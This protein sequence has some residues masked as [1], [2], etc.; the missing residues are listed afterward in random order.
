MAY[1]VLKVLQATIAMKLEH[2][3]TIANIGQLKPSLISTDNLD[4]ETRPKYV[5][6]IAKQAL[7]SQRATQFRQPVEQSQQF[8]R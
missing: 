3:A 6:A 5:N 8:R 2:L 7:A 1:S 4:S